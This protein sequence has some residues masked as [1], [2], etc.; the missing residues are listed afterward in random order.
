MNN[1]KSILLLLTGMFLFQ[2]TNPTSEET[3]LS[4]ELSFTNNNGGITLPNGFQAVVVADSVGSARHIAVRDNGDIYVAL[5]VKKKGGGIAALRDT[6][7]DGTADQVEYFGETTGTGMAIHDDYLYFSSKTEVFRVPL[8]D[9]LVPGGDVDTV[10]SGFPEQGQHASKP[11]TFDKKENMYVTV[12]GPSNACQEEARTKGSPGI[13]PCPQLEWHGGIWRFDANQT[14]QTQQQD[15]HRYATGIRNAVALDWNNQTGALYAV[16][17]GRDQLGTLWPDLYNDKQ[18]AQLPS[19]DF[20]LIKEGYNF[21][22]PYTYY[23]WQ[24]NKRMV[25]PEYGGDGEKTAEAGKYQ[26]PIL[27]F[28]GHWAPNDLTFYEGDQFPSR[29]LHG[30]FIAFHGSW[31]RAPEPQAGYNVAFVPMSGEQPSGDYEIFADGFAGKDS[32][33]AP[34]DAT[35]RPTGVT[36][37]PD[38]SLYVTD[39]VK[40]KIWR[41]VYTGDAE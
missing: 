4:T 35:S 27:T 28:P 24:K 14:G 38:G 11:F 22:W 13:D 19:E 21:G 39:S 33:T 12:G 17:H 41:I 1:L 31:N 29:Y 7:Q 8:D 2:C 16:Q 32:F 25:V 9:N 23:D 10:I 26:D 30:A 5:R 18:N 40:G 36:V 15:G 20:L 6:N 34:S 3:E 37:G